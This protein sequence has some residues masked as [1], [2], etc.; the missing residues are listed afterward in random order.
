MLA[1]ELR[2]ALVCESRLCGPGSFVHAGGLALSSRRVG[3][4]VVLRHEISNLSRLSRQGVEPIPTPTLRYFPSRAEGFDRSE[5][6]AR[7]RVPSVTVDLPATVHTITVD[8][9]V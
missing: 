9:I 5:A 4:S 2:E 6:K 3:A 7:E 8:V 1:H